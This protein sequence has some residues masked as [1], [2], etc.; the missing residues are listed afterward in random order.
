MTGSSLHSYGDQ[1]YGADPRWVTHL[2]II[3]PSDMEF[4]AAGTKGMHTHN[5]RAYSEDQVDAFVEDRAGVRT[6][7]E[8][9]ISEA[10]RLTKLAEAEKVLALYRKDAEK[11][12]SALQHYPALRREFRH[13]LHIL[14]QS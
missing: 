12:I 9:G 8:A 3:H 10:V 6:K 2:H 14:P 13:A 1:K 11:L 7:F 5:H 4:R